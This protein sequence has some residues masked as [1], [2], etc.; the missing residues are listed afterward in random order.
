M[1]KPVRKVVLYTLTSLAGAV[2]DPRRYFPDADATV[3]GAPVFD[4][5]TADLE[6]RLSSRSALH[7]A[8]PSAIDHRD[9]ARIGEPRDI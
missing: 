7:G 6:T 1:G 4:A 8:F 9:A 3:P 2:D 5:A